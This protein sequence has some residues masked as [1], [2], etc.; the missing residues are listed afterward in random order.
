MD[1]QLTSDTTPGSPARHRT[2]NGV[3][4]QSINALC[5]NAT[6]IGGVYDMDYE[7]CVVVTNDYYI[8]QANGL[9]RGS[10]LLGVPTDAEG[11]SLAT[12][13]GHALL[14][15]LLKRSS[16]P[17]ESELQRVREETARGMV[18]NT[19]R[20]ARAVQ[21][22]PITRSEIQ[23][24]AYNMRIVGTLYVKD[25][26]LQFGNDVQQVYATS[27]Y[28]ALKPA[29]DTLS[30]VASFPI[31]PSS[32]TGERLGRVRY[33]S[34]EHQNVL[35]ETAVHVDM[36]DFI[37]QKTALFGMTRTGKSNTVKILA[38]ATLEH[39]ART[40]NQIG[41]LIF[42]T[43]GEYANANRQDERALAELGTDLVSV[44]AWDATASDPDRKPLRLN[45][46]D[47]DMI[48]P[49]WNHLTSLLTRDADYVNSFKNV[50]PIGPSNP[51]TGDEWSTY[52]RASWR[53]SALYA[54][55]IKAGFKPPS[56]FSMTVQIKEEIQ[57]LVTGEM[58][59]TV[60]T[61]SNGQAILTEDNIVSFWETV[62][63][64]RSAI[65][66]IKSDWIDSQLDAVLTMLV[67]DRGSGFRLLEPHRQYH[68][69]DADGYYAEQIYQDLSN[70]TLVIVDLSVGQREA[71]QYLAERTLRKLLSEAIGSF[72][73]N[74]DCPQIQVYIEE[75]H[76]LFN[77]DAV[78]TADSD[79]PYVRLARE[80]AKYNLGLVY[81]TQQIS[82]IDR[83]I[84]SETANWVVTHLNNAHEMNRLA[85]HYRFEDYEHVIRHAP[86]PGFAVV[87]TRS[88]RYSV[89]VQIDLFD[90]QRLARTRQIVNSNGDM[91]EIGGE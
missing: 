9:S 73:A 3:P 75:A 1:S 68:T 54:A 88:S 13:S 62:A 22:D 24:S 59:E 64:N 31:D 12:E 35:D 70:G 53:R 7:S 37:G 78:D 79:D 49:V 38:S 57:S 65:A 63:A 80:G 4:E 72:T 61:T 28:R 43:S 87:R 60:Q 71:I 67:A 21:P 44:Y 39:S 50:N 26:K 10:L 42:D 45:F 20:A 91:A 17:D 36:D 25:G 15:R 30:T 47:E 84:L 58:A 56:S 69:R 16:L 66:D 90:A 33:A 55:L 89:P 34:S 40:N 19:G 46:F 52:H 27:T 83:Q 6:E 81:A 29:P 23:R 82:G 5:R 2:H 85:D 48:E 86:D 76:N 8:E 32:D 11:Q 14:L 77:R 74:D 18:S 51:Q 41:Q